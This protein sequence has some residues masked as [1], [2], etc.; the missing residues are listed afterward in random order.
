MRKLND[1]Q[2]ILLSTAMQRDN[3]SLYPLPDTIT[4]DPKRK[5]NAIDTL[6]KRGLAQERETNDR[7]AIH[8]TDGDIGLGVF[9]T[10]AGRAAIDAGEGGAVEPPAP[11]AAPAPRVT[12]SALVLDLLRRVDGATLPELID[13]TG[14]LPHTTR[15]ALTGLRKKGHGIERGKRGADTCYKCAA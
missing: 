6:L 14:W 13:A 5:A 8:R 10:D 2:L 1:T 15:A 3:G 7:P 12:K 4:G 11:A 9:L